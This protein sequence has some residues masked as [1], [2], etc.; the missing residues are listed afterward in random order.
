MAT[1]LGLYNAALRHIGQR[2]LSALSEVQESRYVLDDVY[3]EALNY[4][5]EQ[6]AWNFAVRTQ[7][8]EHDTG[9]TPEFGYAYGFEKPTD[10]VRTIG[11]SANDYMNPPLVQYLDEAGY[12]WADVDPLYVRFVSNDASYGLDLTKW[13][14]TF[15]HFVE[16]YLA[17]RICPTVANS[18]EMTDKIESRMKK[19]R[20]DARSKDAINDPVAFPPVGSWVSARRS[21]TFS[22]YNRA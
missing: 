5:L 18:Q 3:D 14:S 19:A 1:K 4:C 20:T 11:L 6:G 12:W 16:L 9:I 7:E 22:K 8:I 2:K 15:T 10:W 13:P 21:G 17:Y